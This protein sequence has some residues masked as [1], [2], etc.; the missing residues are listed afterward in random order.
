MAEGQLRQYMCNADYHVEQ[1]QRHRITALG[2][3]QGTTIS[4]WTSAALHSRSTA[5]MRAKCS[6]LS[7]WLPISERRVKVLEDVCCM[8][9]VSRS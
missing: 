3:A 7:G 1:N 6:A 2:S 8:H 4:P 9:E 5:K